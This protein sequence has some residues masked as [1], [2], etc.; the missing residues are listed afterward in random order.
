METKRLKKVLAGAITA[1]LIS[2]LPISAATT[3]FDITGSVLE[4]G[5][6][7]P[8]PGAALKIDDGTI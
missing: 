1:L 6:E 2:G 5:S 7:A 4:E 3:G 8:I